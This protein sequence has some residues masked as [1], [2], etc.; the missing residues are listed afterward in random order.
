MKNF[1]RGGGFKD[2]KGSGGFGRRDSGD[3]GF[4]R[5]GDNSSRPAMFKAICA[6]CGQPC[7]VPFK[8]SGNRPVLCSNCFKGKDGQ[9]SS[10]PA[11]RDFSRSNFSDKPM[12]KAICAECGAPCEV[13]FK[14][15]GDR[16]ILCS[17]CFG[18]TDSRGKDSDSHSHNH[19]HNNSQPSA[20][21]FEILN[22]KLDKILRA[23]N[24]AVS[25]EPSIK[26]ETVKEI[27]I[28]DAKNTTKKL[29]KKTAAPKTVASKKAKKK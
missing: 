17:T 5:G 11:G 14:P 29:D 19:S 8:P 12:F 24:P 2:R 15:S 4:N 21:Q 18:K 27:K 7:E 20:E 16:P 26:K 9:S 1:N 25:P 13:P 10:R 23:L 22:A 28:G 3:K 6:E